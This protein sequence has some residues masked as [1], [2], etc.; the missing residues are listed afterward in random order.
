MVSASQLEQKRRKEMQGPR[1]VKFLHINA[2]EGVTFMG[3]IPYGHRKVEN[4]ED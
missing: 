4:D 2:I 3:E 1:Q